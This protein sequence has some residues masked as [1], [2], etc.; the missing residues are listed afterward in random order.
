MNESK[1]KEICKKT[2][3]SVEEASMSDGFN[4]YLKQ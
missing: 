3:F 4:E 1:M 2:L